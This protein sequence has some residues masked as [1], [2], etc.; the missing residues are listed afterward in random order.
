APEPPPLPSRSCPQPR[1]PTA[2]LPAESGAFPV[3]TQ[4]SARRGEGGGRGGGGR[5]GGG[6]GRGRYRAARRRRASR[7]AP[8]ATVSSARPTSASTGAPVLGRRPGPAAGGGVVAS[9]LGGAVVGAGS[10]VLGSSV[11]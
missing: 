7:P 3:T 2:L 11:G 6:P 4:L 9:G 10:A 1:Q 8:P 5:D